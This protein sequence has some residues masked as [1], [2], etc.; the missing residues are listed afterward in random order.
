MACDE[1]IQQEPSLPGRG[2]LRPP[3]GLFLVRDHPARRSHSTSLP[4]VRQFVS[5]PRRRLTLYHEARPS[6]SSARRPGNS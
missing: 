5:A 6:C 1:I 2:K 4:R 3:D